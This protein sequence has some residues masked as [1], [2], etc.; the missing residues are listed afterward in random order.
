MAAGLVSL[1]FFAHEAHNRLESFNISE[2]LEEHLINTGYDLD[3]L[4]SLAFADAIASHD[5]R[6]MSDYRQWMFGDTK[7]LIDSYGPEDIA[8]VMDSLKSGSTG[9]SSQDRQRPSA[10]SET[11]T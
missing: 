4:V 6:E 5:K 3:Y 7:P 2:D 1:L 8:R 9:S 11:F 10:I